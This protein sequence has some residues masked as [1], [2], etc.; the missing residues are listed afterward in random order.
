MKLTWRS[1][2]LLAA[3]LLRSPRKTWR[4]WKDLRRAPVPD[5]AGPVTID[6][7]NAVRSYEV[8]PADEE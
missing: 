6:P 8:P 3:G 1:Y 5:N 2:F 4:K 7:V